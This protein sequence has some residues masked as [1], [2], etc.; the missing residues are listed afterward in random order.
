MKH[1]S[2]LLA[3]LCL[4]CATNRIV[5]GEREGRWKEKTSDGNQTYKSVGRYHKGDEIKRWRHYADGKLFKVEKY[6]DTVCEVTFYHP[7]GKV[8]S[9]GVTKVIVTDKERHWFYSGDWTYFDEKGTPTLIRT[10]K[11]GNLLSE[12]TL[13]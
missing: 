8:A 12:K 2:L 10:Y 4:S 3:L 5:D 9:K 7:N 11:E 1:P 13:P 6:R